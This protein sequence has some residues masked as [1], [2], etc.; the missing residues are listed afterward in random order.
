MVD[1]ISSIM[2]ILLKIFPANNFQMPAGGDEF[3]NQKSSYDL[4]RS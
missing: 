1:F 3:L 2:G 4:C